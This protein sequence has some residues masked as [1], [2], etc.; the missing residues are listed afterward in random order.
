MMLSGSADD[1]RWP[2][3]AGQGKP[4]CDRKSDLASMI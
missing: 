3:G 4:G 2:S 1:R